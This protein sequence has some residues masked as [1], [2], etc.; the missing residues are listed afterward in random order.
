MKKC[1]KRVFF[2]FPIIAAFMPPQGAIAQPF[3]YIS[4]NDDDTISVVDTATNTVTSTV[5]VGDDPE[6]VA[7]N[8]AGTRVYVTN[9]SDNTVSVINTAT[10]TVTA[11]VPVG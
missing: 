6:G 10:N 7:V 4:N 11:T 8:P 3:A 9:E 1:L 2:W 5:P